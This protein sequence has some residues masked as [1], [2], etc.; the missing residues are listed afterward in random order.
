MRF[1]RQ[2]NAIVSA[3]ISSLYLQPFRH[4][5]HLLVQTGYE[6]IQHENHKLSHEDDI[7]KR[8]V[9][10]IRSYLKSAEAPRWSRRYFVRD[11]I[12][13]SLPNT[14]ARRRPR[15]DIEMES[16]AGHRPVFHFEAKR[17][18]LKYSSVAAYFGS[19]GLGCFL[20]GRYG[21]DTNQGGMLGYVQ[22][23]TLVQW[24]TRLNAE[25]NNSAY[26]ATAG[27]QWV[28][29]SIQGGPPFNFL[30]MHSRQNRPDIEIY[31]VLLDFT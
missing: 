14:P 4:H 18:N 8:I 21:S 1:L 6:R 28:P 9:S 5:C 22:K 17:L 25:L 27:H 20:Q 23:P 26:Q 10:E 3:Q 29:C 11:Q 12:S 31:H 30:T 2:A 13:Q 7:S 15:V 19:E 24:S 16:S